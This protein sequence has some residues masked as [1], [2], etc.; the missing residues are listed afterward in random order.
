[1]LYVKAGGF[2]SAQR[3]ETAQFQWEPLVSLNIYADIL[4][5]LPLTHL[6]QSSR[7][8]KLAALARP[9]KAEYQNFH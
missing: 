9:Y 6:H 1:M 8:E 7:H 2:G 4:A 5:W 3:T